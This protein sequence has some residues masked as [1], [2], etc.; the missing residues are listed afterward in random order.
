MIAEVFVPAT[1]GGTFQVKKRIGSYPRVRVKGGGGGVVSQAGAVLLV[2]TIR[3]SGLNAAVSA[4]LVPWRKPRAV[5]DPGKILL[6]VA[7]AVALGG[8]CLADVAMLRAEPAVLGPGASDPTVSRLV[9]K[10]ASGGQ[11]VLAALRVARAEVRQ[12]VWRLAGEAAPDSGGQV[13]VDIDGV[14]VLAHSQK[15]DAAATWKKTF[16]HHPLTGFVDHGRGGSG[17]PVVGVLRP[18]NAGSNT[19]AD[20]IEAT[21]LALAQLPKRLRRGR[22]T[23]TAPTPVAHPRVRRLARPARK[24][25]VVLRRH[26]HHRCHPPGRLE[27]P[28]LGL[29]TGRG[30]R[31]RHPRRR[32]GRRT[33]GNYL[34]GWPKVLRLIVRKERPHP[35]AQLR[36]TTPTAC[37]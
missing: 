6:D 10:S 34:T 37:G 32:L 15:Q 25:A 28:G 13:I 33:P 35:G 17:E 27:G 5:H 31:R 11:R 18:G 29:D 9:S 4:A 30:T 36:F 8:D 19:A 3:N 14:L 23:L 7:L 20:R 22:Q 12:H 26:D 1:A 24:V 16:G 21:K 2:E